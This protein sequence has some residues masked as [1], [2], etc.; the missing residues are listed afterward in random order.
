ML[1]LKV[2]SS[3]I[4]KTKRVVSAK[5]AYKSAQEKKK[6]KKIPESRTCSP[7]STEIPGESVFES[8]TE[9]KK[10]VQNIHQNYLILSGKKIKRTRFFR[11]K[12]SSSNIFNC[13]ILGWVRGWA[14]PLL[15]IWKQPRSDVATNQINVFQQEHTAHSAKAL[16]VLFYFQVKWREEKMTPGRQRR[17]VRNRDNENFKRK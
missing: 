2:T 14:V 1:V 13:Y 9:S 10:Q 5:S 3:I 17:R 16:H 4:S 12:L 8:G 6:K 7:K 11:Q 15:C